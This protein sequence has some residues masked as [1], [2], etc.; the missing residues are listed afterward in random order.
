MRQCVGR[1]S[2]LCRVGVMPSQIQFDL[3]NVHGATE[4]KSAMTC[5][6][7]TA[8]KVTTMVSI[9]QGGSMN[10][11]RKSEGRTIEAAVGAALRH[12]RN[13]RGMRL[14]ALS[15]RT[16]IAILKIAAIEKGRA[17]LKVEQV[18][19][20][21]RALRCHP[22]LLALFC[23]PNQSASRSCKKPMKAEVFNASQ[24]RAG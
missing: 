16:G 24:A 6:I 15:D 17:R 22:S 13:V 5:F 14:A 9:E 7:V 20:L 19:A 23:G 8:H 12:M 2:A 18:R 21:A 11:N 4:I 3:C 10:A 1:F